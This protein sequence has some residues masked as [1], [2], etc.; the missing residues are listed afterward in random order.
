MQLR[1]STKNS[2]STCGTILVFVFHRRCMKSFWEPG[3]S[4]KLSSY[5][6]SITRVLDS[7]PLILPWRPST[8]CTMM[9]AAS[10]ISNLHYLSELLI[11]SWGATQHISSVVN[12]QHL[13]VF[14][15]A[16][17]FKFLLM[18]NLAFQ[19]CTITQDIWIYQKKSFN[20]RVNT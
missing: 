7:L 20:F 1:D 17:I 12:V 16:T 13:F 4:S 2:T 8:M 14:T 15:A 10:Q 5:F 19:Q 3:Q 11:G 18:R 6:I 9:L